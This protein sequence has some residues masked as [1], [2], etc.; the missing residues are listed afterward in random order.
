M[1]SI[2]LRTTLAFFVLMILTRLLGKK[3]MSQMTYF[4]YITGITI[5]SLTANII[6]TSSE[7]ITDEITGLL[8]WVFLVLLIAYITL[9]SSKLRIIIDGQPTILI[10]KGKLLKNTLKSTRLNLDDLSMM[11]RTKDIFSIADVDYA[12]LEPNGQIT[13]LKK[14]AQ[15]NV[16]RADI[17]I[18]TVD[19]VYLP[20][21]I[22]TD[23]KV[24]KRNLEEFGLTYDW[25]KS[26]L[27]TMGID[28]IEDVFYAEI[29]GDGKLYVDRD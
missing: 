28:N 5:G 9:K 8:W 2:I 25:L 6:S 3:Q 10:R 7:S 16:T 1:L 19:P 23:G 4:N 24:V 11:L 29:L 18:P 17:N 12:I 14:Q 20:S 13:V 26:Q 21:E 22:I 27:K 15:L